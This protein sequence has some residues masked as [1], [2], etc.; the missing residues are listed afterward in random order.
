MLFTNLSGRKKLLFGTQSCC[1]GWQRYES[2]PGQRITVE[3]NDRIHLS[4]R[5]SMDAEVR[6]LRDPHLDRWF[7]LHTW[8]DLLVF[9]FREKSLCFRTEADPMRVSNHPRLLRVIDQITGIV[10][11]IGPFGPSTRISKRGFARTRIAAKQNAFSILAYA[12][13]VDIGHGGSA[14]QQ[15][16]NFLE[17]VIAEVEPVIQ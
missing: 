8:R 5:G 3:I 13:G 7:P 6:N 17:E 10:G 16:Y 2:C 14:E 15:I 4:F 9:Q 12:G 1:S 11:R